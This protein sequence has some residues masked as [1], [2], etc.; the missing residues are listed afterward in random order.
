MDTIIA[1]A[2]PF[3]ESA[4]AVIRVSGVLC[5]E[6]IK[7]ACRITKIK[8][9]Y[10]NLAN[11]SNID[12]NYLDQVVITY[13]E[14]GKSY[15]GEESLEIACHGNPIIS[16]QISQDLIKRGCRPAEPGE[17]TKIS[18][19]NGK[20]DLSQAES[21]AEVI[22]AKNNKYLSAALRNLKGGLSSRLND[23]QDKI[24]SLQAS[25]EAY[26]DFPEDDIGTEDRNSIESITRDIKS[27]IENIL[28]QASKT[29]FLKR[30]I[31]VALV[32]LPNAGKSSLFN[33]LLG[34]KR[35]LVHEKAGTTRDYIEQDIR[36]NDYWVTIVDTA[37]VNKSK[38]SV[39]M[40]GVQLTLQQ[41]NDSDIILWVIDNSMPYPSDEVNEIL[42]KIE[43]KPTL[44]VRNKV[45]LPAK[46]KFSKSIN[47]K[48]V[49]VSCY[50]KTGL[51]E[52]ITEVSKMVSK[53]YDAD[54]DTLL[55]NKRHEINFSKCL[56]EIN[57]FD[58]LIRNDSGY[59][60]AS[61]HII[62]A[63]EAIDEIIG[64]KTTEN[65]LDK[66]FEQFCIGK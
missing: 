5:Q 58:S 1:Q 66:L 40:D 23:I 17:F 2:T 24:L 46:L 7:N 22:S 27:T 62:S 59:E 48:E 6:I 60:L 33:E 19:L 8:P 20:I 63:R 37:G 54:E 42:Q 47:F 21:V 4:I 38:N 28:Y 10:A 26:I 13:F 41:L 29:D 45:D 36:I 55:I 64:K 11:Y 34:R 44:L 53:L 65:M 49:H 25:I 39:E 15:T 61:I 57:E 31:R 43:E 16:E 3:G 9:R 35:A 30:N 18:F 51:P 50:D 56:D 14:K 12:G 52:V 32:G